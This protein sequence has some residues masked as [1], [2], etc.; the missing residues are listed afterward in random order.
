M[1][2]FGGLGL[3]NQMGRYG[4]AIQIDVLFFRSMFL[5]MISDGVPVTQFALTKHS[6]YACMKPSMSTY[7]VIEPE[8]VRFIK[9]WIW[10]K[11]Q[12]RIEPDNR[13]GPIQPLL[14]CIPACGRS[15]EVNEERPRI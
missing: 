9:M 1:S 5:E 11:L 14:I 12:Q 13:M 15:K 4:N 3:Y 2:L 8:L 6:H 10:L 7:K